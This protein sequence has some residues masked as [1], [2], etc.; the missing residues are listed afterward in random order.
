MLILLAYSSLKCINPPNPAG[1]LTPGF[2]AMFFLWIK[3]IKKPL[4]LRKKPV[5][6]QVEPI[7]ATTNMGWVLG[8]TQTDGKNDYETKNKSVFGNNKQRGCLKQ[9]QN[10]WYI[11]ARIGNSQILRYILAQSQNSQ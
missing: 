7:R 5:T 2:C 10:K 9:K 11:Y 6:V 3:G 4:L 1:I 8:R